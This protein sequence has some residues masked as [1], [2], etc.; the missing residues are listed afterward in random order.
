FDPLAHVPLRP[1]PAGSPPTVAVVGWFGHGNY[2]DELFL[3]VFREHLGR[4]VQLRS[5][6]DPAGDTVGRRLGAGIREADAILIGGGDIVIPG[7][8]SNRYWEGA[9]LTR[10][11]FVAGVGVPTWRESTADELTRL[12]RFF[13]SPA[14]RFVGVRDVESEAWI[15]EHLQPR[16]V[17]R[18]A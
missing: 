16:I 17:V 8:T 7:S 11:V 12:R 9:S 5:L 15:R 1:R 18:T 2:G 10:P 14:V 6:L 3:R 4:D 13:R